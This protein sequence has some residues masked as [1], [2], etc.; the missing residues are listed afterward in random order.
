MLYFSHCI[1]PDFLNNADKNQSFCPMT[2]PN[3]LWNTT[4][5][6]QLM[7][8]LPALEGK[9]HLQHKDAA[10]EY[11]LHVLQRSWLCCQEFQGSNP[12]SGTD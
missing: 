9:E 10:L 2:E 1:E 11:R 6:Y 8:K 5:H 3:N 7:T 4:I 12:G